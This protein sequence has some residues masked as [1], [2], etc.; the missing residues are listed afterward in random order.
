M[1]LYQK[2]LLNGKIREIS[3]SIE[4]YLKVHYPSLYSKGF[5]RIKS[6]AKEKLINEISNDTPSLNSEPQYWPMANIKYNTN[7]KVSIIVPNYNHARFLRKRLD[8]I[9]NQTYKNIE[10]ILLDDCSTDN[11]R[12]ILEEYQKKY[13]AITK[14]VPNVKNS[15]SVFK[16]WQKG[17]SLATGDLIWIAESDDWCDDNFWIIASAN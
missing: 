6:K 13:A 14:L 15:G 10:V 5:V 4:G 1:G 12:Q 11:S 8:S 3:K 7:R 16:Q 9:Y 17:I 2:V